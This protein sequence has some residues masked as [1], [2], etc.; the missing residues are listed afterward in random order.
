M[1]WFAAVAMHGTFEEEDAAL[2]VHHMLALTAEWRRQGKQAIGPKEIFFEDGHI[3]RR[4][5]RQEN[6]RPIEAFSETHP[7]YLAALKS[8]VDDRVS[9]LS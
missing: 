9:G 8:Y 7:R 1:G 2:K 4:P 6:Y 3:C 5:F